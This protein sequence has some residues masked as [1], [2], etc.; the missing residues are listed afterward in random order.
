MYTNIRSTN[1]LDATRWFIF[2]FPTFNSSLLSPIP[3]L[4]THTDKHSHT[5]RQTLTHT[6][7]LE[8]AV[9]L[10]TPLLSYPVPLLGPCLEGGF[11]TPSSTA[12]HSTHTAEQSRAERHTHSMCLASWLPFH[13]VKHL[14]SLIYHMK[15][16][17][18]R[19]VVDR[20]TNKNKDN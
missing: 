15:Q 18:R 13:C 9:G 3:T 2:H 19:R 8:T 16:Q 11:V 14:S 1:I 6:H 20:T 5:H 7:L 10:Y 12:Q 4:H 17:K